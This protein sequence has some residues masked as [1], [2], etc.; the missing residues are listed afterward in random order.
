[1]TGADVAPEQGLGCTANA[2]SDRTAFNTCAGIKVSYGEGR[3]FTTF[4]VHCLECHSD[5]GPYYRLVDAQDVGRY[6]IVC[7]MA[8]RR[9]LGHLA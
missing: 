7:G 4:M 8:R 5:F 3:K 9:R 1:M 6:C 2:H